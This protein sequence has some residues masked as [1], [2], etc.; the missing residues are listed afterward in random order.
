MSIAPEAD[1][2]VLQRRNIVVLSICQALLLAVNSTVITLNGLAGFQLA[3]NKSLATLPVTCWVLGGA[4][5]TF[6]ASF[7]MKR[8]GRQRGFVVGGAVGLVGT[9][10]SASAL[11]SGRFW[12]LCLGTLAFGMSNAFG[13][14]FRFAAADA[15]HP[16]FRARAI[17]LVLAGGLVGGFVGPNLSAWT[18]DLLSTRYLAS[19]VSTAGFL[20]L[21][22]AA[23]HALRIPPP[24]DAETS[25]PARSLTEIARQPAYSVAVI[26]AA[27]SYG[28]MNLLMTA[29]PLAMGL[30]GH[31]FSAA[32][33]VTSAHIVAMYAPSLVTG[34]IM[35]RTGVVTVMLAGAVMLGACAAIALAGITVAHFWTSLVLL[36]VGWNCLYVGATALL[37]TTYRP[38]EKAKAQ[39]ANEIAIFLTMVTSSTASGLLLER[40]GWT[41]INWTSLPF[42]L[43]AAA[44]LVWLA[45]RQRQERRVALSQGLREQVGRGLS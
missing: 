15:A 45:L 7:L 41:V 39:G 8:I 10:I 6:P 32:A 36:G 24:S 28:V 40:G 4:V 1:P 26:A 23:A 30:H 25:G 43:M 35:R 2:Y 18:I 38:S 44:L 27:T 22:L 29:T 33:G 11:S 16:R 34:D 14:Y 17:S 42:A 12:Q 13:Q 5:A 19:Y 31:P 20:I 37:T 9:A 21:M 3:T